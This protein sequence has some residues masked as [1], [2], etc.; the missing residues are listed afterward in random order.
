MLSW[1]EWANGISIFCP[2]SGPE[3]GAWNLVLQA[4]AYV[5]QCVGG[6][7]QIGEAENVKC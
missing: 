6:I 1:S 2:F 5:N 7:G 4:C 3:S